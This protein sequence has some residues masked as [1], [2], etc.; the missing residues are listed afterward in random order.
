MAYPSLFILGGCVLTLGGHAVY[1]RFTGK[2]D[3]TELFIIDKRTNKKISLTLRDLQDLYDQNIHLKQKIDVLTLS[4]EKIAESQ[5]ELLAQFA[6]MIEL[7]TKGRSP[8]EQSQVAANNHSPSAHELI[9][10]ISALKKQLEL[11][12]E[13]RITEH[14]SYM[15]NTELLSLMGS[16][17]L[18]Q[19]EEAGK[20]DLPQLAES[21]FLSFRY[22]VNTNKDKS[23]SYVHVEQKAYKGGGHAALS[24]PH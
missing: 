18:Y 11:E 14:A 17:L 1:T 12:K 7:L 22:P 24:K 16:H 3:V 20:A 19:E 8:Q 10:E 6:V 15:Q 21:P 23:D 2:N 13:K 5:N 4:N 9:K